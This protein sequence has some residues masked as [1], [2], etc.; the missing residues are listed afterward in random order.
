MCKKQS[1]SH[2]LVRKVTQSL[3]VSFENCYLWSDS[4]I[5]LC[6]LKLLPNSLKTFV[7]H[8]VAEIQELTSNYYWRHVPT[9]DNPADL[10]SRGIKPSK[11]VD[12][13]LWWHG[14]A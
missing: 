13:S 8:R 3:K 1:G 5:V 4:T 11:I 2:R 9:K 14:P 12:C 10:I 7:S 6:W